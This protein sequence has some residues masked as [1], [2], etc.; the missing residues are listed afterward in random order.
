MRASAM[1]PIIVMSHP[2]MPVKCAAVTLLLTAKERRLAT[3]SSFESKAMAKVF[4]AVEV[5]SRKVIF[6]L[7][8]IAWRNFTLRQKLNTLWPRFGLTAR[9]EDSQSYVRSVI[10]EN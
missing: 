5:R 4:S 10:N 7:E 8:S 2:P 1:S 3:A 6:S 9:S